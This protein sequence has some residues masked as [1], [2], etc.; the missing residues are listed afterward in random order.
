MMF[1]IHWAWWHTSVIPAIQQA[2]AGVLKVKGLLREFSEALP[3]NKEIKGGCGCCS[4]VEFLLC[5]SLGS[6]FNLR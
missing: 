2:E 3:Q 6:W 4:V 1:K 5:I